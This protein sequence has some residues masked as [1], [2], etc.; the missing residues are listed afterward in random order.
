M[1]AC[2]VVTYWDGDEQVT[3]SHPS[4]LIRKWPESAATVPNFSPSRGWL[5]FSEAFFA[6]W[7]HLIG[8]E[9]KPRHTHL[10]F[11]W[12][13]FVCWPWRT[14]EFSI[15]ENDTHH[16]DTCDCVL[17]PFMK[18][19]TFLKCRRIKCVLRNIVFVF[20]FWRV[21]L[22]VTF[23]KLW[24]VFLLNVIVFCEK[25]SLVKHVLCNIVFIKMYLCSVKRSCAKWNVNRHQMSLCFPKSLFWNVRKYRFS[26]SLWIL[27]NVIVFWQNMLCF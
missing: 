16:T 5:T 3:T 26:F 14:K 7:D 19:F 27:W 23:V 4:D 6:R 11:F 24:N 25:L 2:D 22:F 9:G 15:S 8:S 1:W 13:L 10:P 20:V 17:S 18:Y 12:Y 21:V